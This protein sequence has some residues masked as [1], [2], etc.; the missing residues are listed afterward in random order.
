MRRGMPP[1][2]RR[3]SKRGR[4]HVSNPPTRPPHMP[5][6]PSP[7]K[8]TTRTGPPPTVPTNLAGIASSSSQVTLALTAPS[9][10]DA[11]PIYKVFR[12]G[13]LI[14]TPATPGYADSGLTASTTYSYAVA[15]VD[16]AGNASAGTTPVKERKSPRLKPPHPPTAHAGVSFAKKKDNPHWAAADRADESGGDRFVVESGHARVD[17]S[18]P[19]RRP[20]DL[21]GVSQWRADRDAGDAGLRG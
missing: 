9:L 6:S 2:G 5:G 13:A 4:A 11:L 18:F 7:K 19:T 14:A 8:K 10:H 21:Q 20:S 15:A 1:R 12:N 16:A 17:R 3:R